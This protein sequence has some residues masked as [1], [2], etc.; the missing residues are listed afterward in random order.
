MIVI[1]AALPSR[2]TSSALP[3]PPCD[4]DCDDFDVCDDD[5]DDDCANPSSTFSCHLK[6]PAPASLNNDNDDK[7]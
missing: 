5:C 6:C 2:V 7:Y 3:Q 1:I 4:D